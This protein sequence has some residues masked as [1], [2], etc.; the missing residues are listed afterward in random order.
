MLQPVRKEGFL[1]LLNQSFNFCAINHTL[2]DCK[3]P[4]GYWNNKDNIKNF[5]LE[6]KD[7][8]NLQTFEDWNSLTQKH[9]INNGGISL[10]NIHSIYEIK[11]LGYPKGISKFE[12]Q[13]EKGYWEKDENIQNL[14]DKLKCKYNLKTQED[15]NLIKKQH[16]YEMGGGSLLNKLTIHDFKLKAYPN[17]NFKKSNPKNVSRFWENRENIDNFLNNL[18]ETLNLKTS[19]DWNLITQKDIKDNGGGNLLKLYSLYEIKCIGFPD[20][21]NLYSKPKNPTGYWNKKENIILFL[22]KLKNTYKLQTHEDWNSIKRRHIQAIGGGKLLNIFSIFEIKCLGFPE[23]I[24]MFSHPKK[25]SGFWDNDENIKNF[26]NNLKE[27]LNLHTN[28]DWN[29]LSFN[30]IQSFGG[31]G[32]VS[33][34]SKEQII[35]KQLIDNELNINKTAAIRSSQRWLFLQI[36]KLFPGEEIV[37]DYFHSEIS[38]ASGFSVQ[39]DIFLTNKNIAIEYHGKQHYEDIPTLAPLEMYNMRDNEK[40][41]LCKQFGV[42]LIVIP[43]W[44]DNNLDSLK[45]KILQCLSK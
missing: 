19:E 24:L 40:E 13:K 26:L 10:L 35:K 27:K 31:S 36:Q 43:F 41:K 4:L 20:G 3:K 30:L 33:K 34:F 16:I 37:E 12:K 15:W 29:R 25:P 32:L 38:R 18:R 23:G 44:W 45:Q 6:I 2:S 5:I 11:C 8:L 22:N 9:I 28:D 17:G 14:I 39:F 42:Q 21:K 7:K 1:F